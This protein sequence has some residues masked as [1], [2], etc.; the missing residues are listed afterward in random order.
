MTVRADSQTADAR[1][2]VFMFLLKHTSTYWNVRDG[3][4]D[5]HDRLIDAQPGGSSSCR[6]R[7]VAD[8]K[9]LDPLGQVLK[10][11]E[12]ATLNALRCRR[13]LE[14]RLRT[15]LWSLSSDHVA[16]RMNRNLRHWLL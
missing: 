14:A 11:A 3:I 4:C 7:Y 10:R 9:T 13:L 5:V 12:R 6:I 2:G 16:Q 1:Y 15:N 8:I